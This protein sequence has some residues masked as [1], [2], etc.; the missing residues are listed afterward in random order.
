MKNI[1]R[2]LKYITLILFTIFIFSVKGISKEFN[3]EDREFFPFNYEKIQSIMKKMIDKNKKIEEDFFDEIFNDDFFD[4]KYDPFVEI[5]RFRK[6]MIK[7][8]GNDYQKIFESDFNEWFEKRIKLEDIKIVYFDNKVEIYIP[9]LKKKNIS[10]N[11]GN[12]Y[13][14]ISYETVYNSD[15]EKKDFK[16][17]FYKS[18]KYVKYVKLDE[19]FKNKEHS[20]EIKDDKIVISFFKK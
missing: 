18:E 20:I 11:I 4:K 14:K 1:N 6:K 3:K 9:D 2:F 10:V 12:D 16:N 19:R 17:S 13:I 7:M 15:I 8:F 5:E